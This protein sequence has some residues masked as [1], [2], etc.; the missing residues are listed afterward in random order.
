MQKTGR[1]TVTNGVLKLEGTAVGV[2]RASDALERAMRV[3]ESIDIL[4]GDEV[5]VEGVLD[6]ID[7]VP[8]LMMS[9]LSRASGSL[10]GPIV[11]N[12]INVT[13]R[14]CGFVN[15]GLPYIDFRKLPTCQNPPSHR[16]KVF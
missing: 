8:V 14:Q 2:H 12:V 4:E 15:R 10:G 3:F 11:P 6:N 16:L 13:C 1:L 9:L 7:N 5:S